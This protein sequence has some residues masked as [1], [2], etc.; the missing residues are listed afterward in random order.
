MNKGPETEKVAKDWWD[1]ESQVDEEDLPISD[2]LKLIKGFYRKQDEACFVMENGL[3]IYP[4]TLFNDKGI[5]INIEKLS[6]KQVLKAYISSLNLSNLGLIEAM[7]NM[8][9]KPDGSKLHT[10][11]GIIRSWS[12]FGEQNSL[13]DISKFTDQQVFD[14]WNNC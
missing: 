3:P 9:G 5:P 10:S 4:W 8:Y 6:D 14:A 13:T 2:L 11:L 1:F 7:R 12:M